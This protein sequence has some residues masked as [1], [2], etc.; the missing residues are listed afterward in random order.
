MPNL[1]E[2]L[3]YGQ[4][5]KKTRELYRTAINDFAK[6]RFKD[7]LPPEP[8]RPPVGLGKGKGKAA[9]DAYNAERLERNRLALDLLGEYIES[10]KFKYTDITKYIDWRRESGKNANTTGVYVIVVRDMCEYFDIT[11]NKTKMRR[12]AKTTD[13]HLTQDA[14]L[15]IS[16][17][18]TLYDNSSV[19]G[20]LTI[21]LL[22]STGTR[23][24]ELADIKI[25]DV[26]L[27]DDPAWICLRSDITKGEKERVVFLTDEA[28]ALAQNWIQTGRIQHLKI[29]QNKGR[30]LPNVDNRVNPDENTLFLG[31]GYDTIR[32]LVMQ[33]VRK[34]QGG[35]PGAKDETTGRFK[36]HAHSFR[37]FFRSA[38]I[39]KMPEPI[40]NKIMGHGRKGM[41]VH[42]VR[43]DIEALGVEFKKIQS[44]LTIG[45][46]E[47]TRD[48]VERS[49]LH[50]ARITAQQTEMERLQKELTETQNMVKEL[51]K[52]IDHQED[53]ANRE[54]D[55]I[56][57]S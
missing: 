57:F 34:S 8:E 17:I 39:G 26:H 36:I 38:L 25:T 50:A 42:Y 13:K 14:S 30:G 11:F 21:A 19:A 40:I 20:Q 43:K 56:S 9:F 22:T 31:F 7:K 32:F 3:D 5:A 2:Y 4:A 45:A 47:V 54:H 44:E 28:K 15:K 52:K 18:K 51:Y 33:A 23:A 12:A 1:E 41:D 46:S 49:G 29:A 16:D 48:L 6:F 55:K 35:V 27:D 37:K 10:G 53:R 24:S